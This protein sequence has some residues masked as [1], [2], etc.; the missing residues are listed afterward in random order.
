MEKH[1]VVPD[2]IDVAPAQIVEVNNIMIMYPDIHFI[3]FQVTYPGGA[4]VEQGNVLTP[5]QVKDIPSVKWEA[6][7]NGLYTV[8]MTGM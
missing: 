7:N 3:H 8:C 4:K 1:G 5:T 6:E 2:V